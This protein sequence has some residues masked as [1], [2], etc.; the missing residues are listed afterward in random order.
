MK[1]EQ[2][3][4]MTAGGFF[5]I[6]LETFKL[7]NVTSASQTLSDATHPKIFVLNWF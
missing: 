6:S 1:A 5:S 3:I 4:K 7:V 2:S